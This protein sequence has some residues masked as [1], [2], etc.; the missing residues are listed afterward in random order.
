MSAHKGKIEENKAIANFII[1]ITSEI[2]NKWTELST[3]IQQVINVRF[4]I[5]RKDNAKA[6]IKAA[7]FAIELLD[8]MNLLPEESAFRIVQ[9]I[10]LMHA[11]NPIMSDFWKRNIEYQNSYQLG[12]RKGEDPIISVS[13][14][15]YSN[16]VL[17]CA[18][19]RD[20]YR[21]L[22]E[23]GALI[24]PAILS[25]LARLLSHNKPFW[26]PL[27]EQFEI[28]E[29]DL[30]VVNDCPFEDY[31]PEK[32]SDHFPDGTYFIEDEQG[33]LM[34]K[35]M[36]PELFLSLI[37][38]GIAERVSCLFKGHQPFICNDC[39]VRE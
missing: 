28:T 9:R 29:S 4:D 8:L 13:A 35:W 16:L 3:I 15:V 23:E 37:E 7:Y 19:D 11:Q 22:S 30:P 34:K 20:R 24:N 38:K 25:N 18:V 33:N 21:R 26:R 31:F 12:I 10:E 2:E 32:E 27:L 5:S 1:F 39:G 6:E 14:L 17:H 36:S